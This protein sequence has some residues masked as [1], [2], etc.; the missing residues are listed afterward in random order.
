MFEFLSQN[1]FFKLLGHADALT[2]LIFGSLIGLSI[3]CWW[4]FLYKYV[5]LSKKRSEIVYIRSRLVTIGN[6]DELVHFGSMMHSTLGG[7]MIMS[8]VTQVRRQLRLRAGYV[9]D[10][11]HTKICITNAVDGAIGDIINAESSL[12]GYIRLSAEGGPL[13]GLFGTIWGLI[14]AFNRISER[15]TAD[16]PTVAPGIAEALVVTLTGLFVAIPALVQYT[17]LTRLLS[18]LEHELVVIGSQLEWILS[19][20]SASESMLDADASRDDVTAAESDVA[21][22]VN[23]KRATSASKKY[24][25][26]SPDNR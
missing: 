11:E 8:T 16:I 15:Q 22:D 2:W 23:I 5:S 26:S 3:V 17:L 12:F 14:H 18:E 10:P 4:L 20:S 25:G 24:S 19:R 7:K 13:I 21:S 1:I 6:F 9:P